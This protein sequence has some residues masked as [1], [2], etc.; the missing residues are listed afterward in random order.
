LSLVEVQAH[1]PMPVVVVQVAS[2]LVLDCQLPQE[3]PT[4]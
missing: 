3:Q 4:P 1:M 2:E